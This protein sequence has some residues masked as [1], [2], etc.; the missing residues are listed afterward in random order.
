MFSPFAFIRSRGPQLVVLCLSLLAGFNWLIGLSY[1]RGYDFFLWLYNAWLA[2]ESLGAGNWPNW[3]VYSASG[4]PV[5]KMAGITDAIILFGFIQLGG[6]EAGTQIYACLLYALA[7]MG[8]FVLARYLVGSVSGSIVA[9]AAYVFSWF[10]TF[11]AY[12]QAYLSNFLSY[13]LMPWCAYLFIR[14]IREHSWGRLLGA[15]GILFLSITSNAQVS[16]K[17]LFFVVPL[18]FVC[19][20]LSGPRDVKGWA[21]RSILLVIFALWWSAFLIAPALAIRQEVMLPVEERGSAFISPLLVLFWIPLF[22]LNYVWYKLGGTSFL[23]REFLAWVIFSDYIGL[24]VLCISLFSLVYF[25]RT[26][27]IQVAG[28]G[29][30][31]AV[32]YLIYFAV[33]PFVRASAWVGRIHNLIILP[34]L[35]LPLLCA[36]GYV[37][38]APRLEKWLKPWQTVSVLCG[39]IIIDLG[40]VSFFLNR[41]AI[42]HTPLEELPEVKVWKELESK[43]SGWD[44]TSRW[45]TS[46][47]D[48]TFY[49]L[50]VLTGK[51][52]ANVIELRTRNWEYDSFVEHQLKSLRNLDRTYN[53]GES[54]ALLNCEYLDLARKLY[55]Y[56]GDDRDFEAGLELLK[57]DPNLELV[58]TRKQEGADQSY[59]ASRSDLHI[60]TIVEGKPDSRLVAQ[61]IFRNAKYHWG[62][63]PERAILLLGD[64]RAGQKMFEEITHLEGFEADRALYVLS[65][66]AEGMDAQTLQAFSACVPIGATILPADLPVWDLEDLRKYYRSVREDTVRPVERTREDSESLEVRLEAPKR[67]SFLF[68]AQQRFNDW[69][70]FDGDG[71]PLK[72]FKAA[73]GLTAILVPAKVSKVLYRYELPEYERWARGISISGMI[74]ALLIGVIGFFRRRTARNA[75]GWQSYAKA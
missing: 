9:A 62:F 32:Y 65:E 14:S 3:S 38:L 72:V 33:M 52:T 56:R 27:D 22:G 42:T 43:D 6:I 4:Q 24:S 2:G 16:I 58:L 44:S 18:A 41:L 39:L 57:S 60:S 49:L 59:D 73:A 50:P 54:L 12:Y 31:L 51:P 1:S 36:Y 35:V 28:L 67:P 55:A 71:R 40:G 63:I 64:S 19:T 75:S 25:R 29:G 61:A 68:L 5:F 23:D 45:F 11:T 74:F 7:G 47:P 8:M 69:H 10:L 13:A 66:S 15:A 46:N 53:A 70:A 37:W 26:R 20:V 34:T 21:C 17:V 30:L 48:H